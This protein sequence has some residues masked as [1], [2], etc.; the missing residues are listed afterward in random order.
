MKLVLLVPGLVSIAAGIYLMQS[1]QTGMVRYNCFECPA[2]GNS[3]IIRMNLL[4]GEWWSG[5]GLVCVGISESIPAFI[6]RRDIMWN[7]R[8]LE[9]LAVLISQGLLAY[10]LSE[11]SF[12]LLSSIMNSLL[13]LFILPWVAFFG[14]RILDILIPTERLARRT[15]RQLG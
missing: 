6:S 10:V 5:L 4:L 12:S 3:D 15:R 11:E 14:T 2:F 7:I 9:V 1:Y 13:L 8:L